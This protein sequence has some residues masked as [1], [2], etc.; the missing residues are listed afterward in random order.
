[1]GNLRL[2]EAKAYFGYGCA[3][4]KSL[5]WS[6]RER[7]CCSQKP[8]PV[9]TASS[10]SCSHSQSRLCLKQYLWLQLRLHVHCLMLKPRAMALAFLL[11]P[12][13]PAL[14]PLWSAIFSAL[15]KNPR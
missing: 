13:A 3:V 10:N 9:A 8:Q 4:A 1:M 11:R 12:L 2:P 5:H 7:G 15:L 14:L 6:I